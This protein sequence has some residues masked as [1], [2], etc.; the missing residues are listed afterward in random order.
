MLKNIPQ[1]LSP[2]LLKTLIKRE[3]GP[4]LK[5]YLYNYCVRFFI[6]N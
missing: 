2:E 3:T 5:M 4:K 6:Y 1:I